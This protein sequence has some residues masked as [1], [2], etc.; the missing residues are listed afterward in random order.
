LSGYTEDS[1]DLI[2]SY[3]LRYH[4]YADDTQLISYWLRYHL[5]ADDTQLIGCAEI[6]DVLSTIDHLSGSHKTTFGLV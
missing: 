6:P 3:W 1:A 4:L 2:A 5:Y